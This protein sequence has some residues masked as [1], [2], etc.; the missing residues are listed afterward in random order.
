MSRKVVAGNWKMNLSLQSAQQLVADLQASLDGAHCKVIIAPPACYLGSLIDACGEHISL[1]AQ[2]CHDKQEG[3]YTGEVSA[4]MLES[5][6]VAYCLVGHSER[7]EYFCEG[8]AWLAEKINALI[9]KGIHPIYCFGEQLDERKSNRHFEVVEQQIREGLFHL[10]D[11]DFSNVILA[12]EPVWAIGTGETATSEQA[13]EM[14]AFIRNL[15]QKQYG[16]AMADRTTILY[17]GSCKPSNAEEL[18]AQPDVD[19]GL[20]GGAA[21]QASD[22]IQIIRSNG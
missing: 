18:F 8:N 20:I 12:Y 5:M 14:H 22:F 16:Q 9:A 11:A 6:G 4:M 3:A 1:A 19:G 17:G 15:V 21:L 10:A 7:R 2:N 13:Q